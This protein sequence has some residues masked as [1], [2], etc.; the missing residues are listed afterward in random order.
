MLL[1]YL[2][3]YFAVLILLIWAAF[4]QSTKVAAYFPY[5]D[6]NNIVLLLFLIA[7][8]VGILLLSWEIFLK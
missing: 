6:F 4:Q 7:A 2:I 1:F 8:T 3:L 5:P